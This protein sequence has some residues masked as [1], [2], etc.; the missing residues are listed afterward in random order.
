M[1]E[2]DKNKVL[3]EKATA[4]TKEL[5][6]LAEKHG[7]ASNSSCGC[8]GGI[9]LDFNQFGIASEVDIRNGNGI[10]EG[11]FTHDNWKNMTKVKLR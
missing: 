1:N 6:L 5:L 11:C 10:L 4:F 7:I 2:E 9:S 3:I 8:C